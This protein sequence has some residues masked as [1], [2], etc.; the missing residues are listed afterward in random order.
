M[1]APSNPGSRFTGR[2]PGKVVLGNS[3]PLGKLSPGGASG[4]PVPAAAR[5]RS[6]I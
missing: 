1:L 6:E 3:R 4:L 5:D 2:H